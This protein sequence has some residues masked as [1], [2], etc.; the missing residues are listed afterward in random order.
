MLFV[1]PPVV[2]HQRKSAG[3]ETER[4]R[5]GKGKHGKEEHLNAVTPKPV[6]AMNFVTAEFCTPAFATSTQKLPI[7]LD[8]QAG[9]CES[10]EL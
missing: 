2:I 4:E 3:D 6:E 7:D 8:E 9:R 10:A 5:R 1:M